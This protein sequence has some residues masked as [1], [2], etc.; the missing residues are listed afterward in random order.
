MSKRSIIPV[1]CIVLILILSGCQSTEE[2]VSVPYIIT[3]DGKGSAA[4]TGSAERQAIESGVSA[5]SEAEE[6][7][8]PAT[9][10]EPA[11]QTEPA[12]LPEIPAVDDF[13]EET[14]ASVPDYCLLAEGDSPSLFYS[15]DLAADAAARE[16]SYYVLLYRG[17]YAG[18]DL[19]DKVWDTAEERHTPVALYSTVSRYEDANMLFYAEMDP[20]E[21]IYYSTLGVRVDESAS[22]AVVETVYRGTP[23]EGVLEKGDVI[24]A[25]NG[26]RITSPASFTQ[27][28]DPIIEGSDREVSITYRRDGRESQ[29]TLTL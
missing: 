23:A 19:P 22:Q 8:A 29:A 4:Q 15:Q 27:V 12:A 13:F 14:G 24:T 11:A 10:E 28:T 17:S 7:K 21:M 5:P 3:R 25:V 26:V 1:L 20:M 9:R 16:A 6:T 18:A 2:K